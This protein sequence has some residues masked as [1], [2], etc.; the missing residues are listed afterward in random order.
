[1]ENLGIRRIQGK[2]RQRIFDPPLSFLERTLLGR[3]ADLMV[4][5]LTLGTAPG[6]LKGAEGPSRNPAEKVEMH[7]RLV[8]EE[9]NLVPSASSR[10]ENKVLGNLVTS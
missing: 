1:M 2:V 3:L 9:N 4:R 5:G 7:Q 8:D 10:N 6:S